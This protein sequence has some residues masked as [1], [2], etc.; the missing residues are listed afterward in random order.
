MMTLQ[1]LSVLLAAA[2]A[3]PAEKP[4]YV[5]RKA[6][7]TPKLKGEW[8][9][10]VWRH[11]EQLE[12]NQFLGPDSEHRPVTHARVLYDAKGLYIHFRVQDKYVRTIETE[13]HGK[14]WQDACAEF[15]VAPKAKRGYFNFEINS[16]G[17]M[18]LSYHEDPEW[19]SEGPVKEGSVPWELA[20]KVVI[21]HSMPK[22]VDP[23]IEEDVVWQIEYHIPFAIFEE[24]VGPL[25]DVAGQEWRANFYKC[26]ENNSHPHWATW[27]PILGKLDFHQP[28][29]FGAIKFEK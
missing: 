23:E 19:K 7:A 11:A 25:G 20:S 12:V 28:Q 21:Y 29:Y 26:A 2:S 14:V 16:G 9:S 4:S 18:L 1:V 27:S 22:T 3:E 17:T 10:P 15:F 13:Y 8:D 6:T 5:V 24:Y